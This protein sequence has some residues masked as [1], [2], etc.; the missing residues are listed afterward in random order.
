MSERD[1][2]DIDVF[3]VL[4]NGTLKGEVEAGRRTGDWKVKVVYRVRGSRDV[5]AVVVVTQAQR[6]VIVTVEWEDLS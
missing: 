4:R 6:L 1:I 5:G 2:L 3:R